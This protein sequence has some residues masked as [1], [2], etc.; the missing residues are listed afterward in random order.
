[1]VSRNTD[2][3]GDQKQR[4]S[5]VGRFLRSPSVHPYSHQSFHSS[6]QTIRNVRWYSTVDGYR[7]LE[8]QQYDQGRDSFHLDMK[9]QHQLLE[10]QPQMKK[11]LEAAAC[12]CSLEA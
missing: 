8:V 4:R 12:L 6:V 9:N 7:F 10:E 2:H 1:M 3:C 5:Q 11:S